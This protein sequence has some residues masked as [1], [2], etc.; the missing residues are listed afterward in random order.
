MVWV[1]M[2]GIMTS[3]WEVIE[4]K[5]ENKYVY[6]IFC[7]RVCTVPQS[8]KVACIQNCN[9]NLFYNCYEDKFKTV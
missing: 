7:I 4:T 2:L 9:Y 3:F 5:L 6:D 8:A 1:E